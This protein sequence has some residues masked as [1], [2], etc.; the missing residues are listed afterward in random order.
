VK[1]RRR[2][3]PS[4]PTWKHGDQRKLRFVRESARGQPK[5]VLRD[6]A[7]VRDQHC[8]RECLGWRKLIR[9]SR[10]RAKLPELPMQIGGKLQFCR[11][12]RLQHI[13]CSRKGTCEQHLERVRCSSRLQKRSAGYGNKI[14]IQRIGVSQGGFCGCQS[15]ES[16][17]EIPG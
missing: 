3:P 4:L 17:L 12:R 11:K 10:A 16:V 13:R 1:T 6:S 14:A 5:R 2:K 8:G 15:A 9:D 7:D